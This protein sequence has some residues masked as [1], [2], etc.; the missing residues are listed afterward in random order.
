MHGLIPRLEPLTLDSL[1]LSE[2]LENLVRDW[3]SRR[4]AVA[5]SV[6]YE[7]SCDLGHSVTLTIYRIVQEGLI[8][9]L[10][11]A[12]P[13]RIEIGVESDAQRIAVSVADDGVGLPEDWRRPGHFGLRGLAERVENLAGTFEVSNRAPR[14]VLLR[15]EIPLRG[16]AET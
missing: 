3:R 4:P 14:G 15:A 13:S 12:Q 2:T 5:L 7:V 1:G 8:N 9:A 16:G 11:H 6:R 10:R